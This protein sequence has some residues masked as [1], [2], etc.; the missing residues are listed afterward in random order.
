MSKADTIG[1]A[2]AYIKL[3]R[4]GVDAESAQ[5]GR[6]RVGALFFGPGALP[7]WGINELVSRA[8]CSG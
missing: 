6:Q 2:R 7:G 1:I 3:E 4:I 5:L 8:L